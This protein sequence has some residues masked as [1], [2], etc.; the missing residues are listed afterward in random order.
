MHSPV[1]L[2]SALDN[3]PVHRAR[4]RGCGNGGHDSRLGPEKAE[5][6]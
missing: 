2:Y 4:D 3:L 1:L 6:A 5:T